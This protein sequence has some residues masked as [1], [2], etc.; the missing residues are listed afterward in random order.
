MRRASARIR[1]AAVVALDARRRD[2]HATV[3]VLSQ[4]DATCACCRF[5]TFSSTSQCM[6]SPAISRSEFVIVP[7]GFF[8]DTSWACI[9]CGNLMRHTIGG[10]LR[11]S[12]NHTPP[13]PSLDASQYPRKSG[14]AGMRSA[15]GVGCRC[16]MRSRWIQSWSAC[17]VGLSIVMLVRGWLRCRVTR[18]TMGDSRPFPFGMPRAAWVRR[19]WI[20]WRSR[21]CTLDRRDRFLSS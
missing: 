19:P 20:L 7:V 18:A 14:F 10:R 16:A 4:P 12:Q 8:W 13:A 3:G 1:C 5:A 2:V 21:T 9:V 11:F 17:F 6:R 15:H